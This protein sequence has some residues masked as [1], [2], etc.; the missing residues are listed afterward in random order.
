MR[1]AALTNGMRGRIDFAIHWGASA[2]LKVVLRVYRDQICETYVVDT[3]AYDIHWDR[4]RRHSGSRDRHRGSRHH[5]SR[6]RLEQA[7]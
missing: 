5:R 3:E 4:H 7:G 6:D 1:D 2:N